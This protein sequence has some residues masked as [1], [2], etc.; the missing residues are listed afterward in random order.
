MGIFSNGIL[1]EFAG[2]IG[3]VVGTTWKG[4]AVMR[5]RP[6]VKK[7]RKFSQTQK[8]Q[9][10]KFAVASGY[11]QQMNE[12]LSMTFINY[13]KDKTALNSALSYALNNSMAGVYPDFTINWPLLLISKGKLP[14]VKSPTAIPVA[15]KIN[16]TWLQNS[17]PGIS[18]PTD[19]A[20]LVV[21]CPSLKECAFTTL[22]GTRSSG[23][24]TIE[25][26]N[27]T[28]QVV[29]TY[30]GFMSENGKLVSN[31]VYTGQQTVL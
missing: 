12:L 8:E 21:I 29:H 9:Q 26:G 13:T 4:K 3:T 22:G 20:V 17:D 31:S 15:G 1:G 7:N 19:R 16:Y 23:A 28:G 10:A 25:V 30:L 24:A 27:F 5:S 11:L 14:Q 6:K 2:K 18:K